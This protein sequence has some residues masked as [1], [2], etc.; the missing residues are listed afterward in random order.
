M[1]FF[2]TVP[3]KRNLIGEGLLQGMQRGQ[4]EA[5]LQ[6]RLEMQQEMMNRQNSQHSSVLNDFFKSQ[7]Q[8]ANPQDVLK[9]VLGLPIPQ[10]MKDSALD[11][12]LKTNQN[13][14]NAVKFD[15]AI[16]DSVYRAYGAST[17][18]SR[19]NVTPELQ[20]EINYANAFVKTAASQKQD[21]QKSLLFFQT[22]WNTNP[23]FR[24]QMQIVFGGAAAEEAQ[25]AEQQQG[26][27]LVEQQ[28]TAPR[29]PLAKTPDFNPDAQKQRT[30]SPFE[31][32]RKKDLIKNDIQYRKETASY[33]DKLSKDELGAQEAIS[34]LETL[35]KI[36]TD[37]NVKGPFVQ[38][39][40][41]VTGMD[42]G[43]FQ[44]ADE[45]QMESLINQFFGGEGGLK[46]L[47]GGGQLSDRD[48]LTFKKTLP[49]MLQSKEGRERAI[50]MMIKM[51]EI[52]IKRNQIANEIIDESKENGE[53]HPYDLQA[54]V[55][56]RMRPV[57]KQIGSKL[58]A[59]GG[60]KRQKAAPGTKIDLATAKKYLEEAGGDK[61]KARAFAAEDGYEL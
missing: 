10:Q 35:K 58:Q 43:A 32:Q 21:P 18:K 12:L 45:Q 19:D 13:M 50:D 53:P 56:K 8:G 22:Q 49:S 23:D 25:K 9:G 1:A 54:Q 30:Q 59:I 60:I 24:K 33:Q 38:K 47:L 55:D 28:E 36:N 29:D 34:K 6:R 15:Q 51:R 16:E 61:E 4:E 41:E 2:V 37:G 46:D 52:K 26:M 20:Q 57:Y 14:S 31:I 44:T 27:G 5:A 40:R 3:A 48:V 11:V 42:F 7:Q 39:F 17:A